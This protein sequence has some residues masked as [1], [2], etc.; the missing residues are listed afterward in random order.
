MKH[1][2]RKTAFL[3][4]QACWSLCCI[5]SRRKLTFTPIVFELRVDNEKVR[6]RLCLHPVKLC[7]CFGHSAAPNPHNY[8][9][10]L[11]LYGPLEAGIDRNMSVWHCRRSSNVGRAICR[12]FLSWRSVI[13]SVRLW[14]FFELGNA[15]EWCISRKK[16]IAVNVG[17]L[18][19]TRRL[20]REV[21]SFQ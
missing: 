10:S 6:P 3:P 17:F 21:R 4:N 9:A 16:T 15:P 13:Y 20:V 11:V 18:Q 5:S 19:M 2:F 8:I 14:I 7:P 12:R 1:A